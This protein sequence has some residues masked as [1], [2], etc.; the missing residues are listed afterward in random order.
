MTL[1]GG[2]AGAAARGG[3]MLDGSLSSLSDLTAAAAG[4]DERA[5]EHLHR[6]VG[7]GL[8]RLLRK[9]SGGREDV[10]EDLS[11]R[12]WASVWRAL[13]DG[14]YDPTRAAVTTFVYAVGHNAW[15]TH[16]RGVAREQA[17]L[18]DV[19]DGQSG[20]AGPL[21]ERGATALLAEAELIDAVRACLKDGSGA[22]LTDLERTI[23]HAIALGEG[24]RAL[25]RRLGMSGSTINKHKH[26]AYGKVRAHLARMGL[27][28]LPSPSGT[29]ED[30][31]GTKGGGS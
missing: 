18:E 4:G 30:Q 7:T 5:F 14:K 23:V 24:D 6:R 12:T 2:G 22:G 9:R 8:R 26:A 20:D 1:V 31:A 11:Q 29:E 10:V 28:E 16:L 25:A 27:V 15:L 3:G 13:R 19:R 17:R 21:R